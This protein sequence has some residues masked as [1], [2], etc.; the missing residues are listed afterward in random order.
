M[1]IVATDGLFVRWLFVSSLVCRLNMKILVFLL[2]LITR[3][4]TR[5]LAPVDLAIIFEESGD[6]LDYN[7][8]NFHDMM[9]LAFDMEATFLE[10]MSIYTVCDGQQRARIGWATCSY[11]GHLHFQKNFGTSMATVNKE[12]FGNAYDRPGVTNML[13][14]KAFVC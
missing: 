8:D 7:F 10:I 12:F 11:G 3:V 5:K 13:F 6:V 14:S 4:E 1:V 9:D 2:H